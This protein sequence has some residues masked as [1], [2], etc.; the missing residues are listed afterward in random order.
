MSLYMKGHTIDSTK[1]TSLLVKTICLYLLS[2]PLDFLGIS[3]LGSISKIVAILPMAVSIL[4]IRQIK[5][6]TLN[7]QP[8]FLILFALVSLLSSLFSQHS[9]EAVSNCVSML[10]NILLILWLPSFYYTECEFKCINK[11][12]FYSGIIIAVLAIIFKYTGETGRVGIE[13]GE[14]SQNMNYI[15]GYLLFPQAYALYEGMSKKRKWYYVVYILLV[16]TTIV[17]GSR[18]GLFSSVAVYI[19]IY[20]LVLVRQKS[21]GKRAAY[22]FGSLALLVLLSLV[23]FEYLPESLKERYTIDSILNDKGS[24]RLLIWSSMLSSFSEFP[25]IN[26]LFGVGAGISHYYSYNQFYVAHNM[27]LAYLLDAGVLGL[28]FYASFTIK[29]IQRSLKSENLILFAALIGFFVMCMTSTFTN[30]KPLWAVL[31]MTMMNTRSNNQALTNSN[32][33]Q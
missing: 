22:I 16:F 8:I 14:S 23:F 31:M 13:V 4:Y 25:F 27:Y 15:N 20:L 10:M 2:I 30:F 9:S 6:K 32:E 26:K 29:S 12:V 18:G 28:L 17:T 21:F 7:Q 1:K 24:N 5:V 33:R 19:T 3:N 11:S